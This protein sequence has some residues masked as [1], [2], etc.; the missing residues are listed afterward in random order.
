M[1]AGEDGYI[2]V[3]NPDHLGPMRI[4]PGAGFQIMLGTSIRTAFASSLDVA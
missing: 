2:Y 4:H 3:G 1:A